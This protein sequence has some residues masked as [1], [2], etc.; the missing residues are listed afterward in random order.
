MFQMA[1]TRSNTTRLKRGIEP[2]RICVSQQLD[3]RTVPIS[4]LARRQEVER[5]PA[6]QRD[7][8][9]G[10]IRTLSKIVVAQFSRQEGADPRLNTASRIPPAFDGKW[11]WLDDNGEPQPK[12]ALFVGLFRP[13]NPYIDKL[14]TTYKDLALAM[15]DGTCNNCTSRTIRKRCIGWF[16]CKHRRMRQPRSRASCRR[17]A[18]TECRA[19]KIGLEKELDAATKASLLKFGR[20]FESTVNAAYAWREGELRRTSRASPDQIDGRIHRAI[21]E[22]G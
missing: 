8:V 10:S 19:M 18:P 2:A 16:C 21:R 1:D 4:V 9:C 12:P 13:D 20:V 11:M 14:Q 22:R 6:C 7:D 15:R 17:S 3:A 5:L